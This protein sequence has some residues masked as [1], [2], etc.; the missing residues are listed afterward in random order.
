MNGG[1]YAGAR[2][3]SEQGIL[4]LHSPAAAMGDGNAYA[5]G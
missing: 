1:K 5:M 2:V 3:L 4:G